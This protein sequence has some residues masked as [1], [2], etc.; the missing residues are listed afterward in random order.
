MKID[1]MIPAIAGVKKSLRIATAPW[2]GTNNGRK[3]RFMA[4]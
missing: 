1:E 3:W 2:I 4:V